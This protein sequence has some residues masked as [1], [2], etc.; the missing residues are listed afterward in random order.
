METDANSNW[1]VEGE[2]EANVNK[3]FG[4]FCFTASYDHYGPS[5]LERAVNRQPDHRPGDS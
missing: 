4:S 5:D 1:G 2:D 3:G